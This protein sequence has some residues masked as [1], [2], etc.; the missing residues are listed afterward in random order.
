MEKILIK[1]GNIFSRSAATIK[2]R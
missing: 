2:L 1:L